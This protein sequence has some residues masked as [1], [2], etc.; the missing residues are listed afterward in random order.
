MIVVALFAIVS[1]SFVHGELVDH[2]HPDHATHLALYK[3]QKID[4]I[5]ERIVLSRFLQSTP[6]SKIPAEIEDD[7]IVNERKLNN[8]ITLIEREGL[9]VKKIVKAT[10]PLPHLDF[11]QWT[12][13]QSIFSNINKNVAKR[14][15]GVKPAKLCDAKIEA[16]TKFRDAHHT[17]LKKSSSQSTREFAKEATFLA[18]I[19]IE[20]LRELK[21]NL[22][23]K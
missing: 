3:A 22:L 17:K 23:K 1:L 16:I 4:Q 18:N 14:S 2:G 21:A 20:L 10:A 15:A 11:E 19:N 12:S 6:A 9:N 7:Q 5:F 13:L 8:L